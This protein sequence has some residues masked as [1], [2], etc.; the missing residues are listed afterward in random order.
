MKEIR[1]M[2][3]K[4]ADLCEQKNIPFL[5]AFG[6]DKIAIVEYA[7]DDTPERIKKAR[8][9]LV[10]TTMQKRRQIEIDA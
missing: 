7:P 9:T 8:T 1:E 2:V 10:N 3:N 5:A 6:T 4:V